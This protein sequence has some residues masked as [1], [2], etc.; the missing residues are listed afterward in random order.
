LGVAYHLPFQ[1]PLKEMLESEEYA[2]LTLLIE[3]LKLHYWQKDWPKR[4]IEK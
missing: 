1:Q 2:E 4:N 3:R